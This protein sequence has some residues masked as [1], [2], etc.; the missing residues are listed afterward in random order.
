MGYRSTLPGVRH[1]FNILWSLAIE[2][3][4]YAVWPVVLGAVWRWRWALA[5]LVL[6]CLAV[7]LWRAW[8]FQHCGA[9]ASAVC[10]AGAGPGLA[11]QPAVSGH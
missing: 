6:L 3:H 5:A 4:Y 8:L 7:L 10:G 9:A 2:E 1:P 11:L